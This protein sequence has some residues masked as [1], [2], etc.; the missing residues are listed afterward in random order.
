MRP[1]LR[2]LFAEL[3]RDLSRR[4]RPERHYMRGPGPAWSA[5]QAGQAGG[6]TTAP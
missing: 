5:K 1:S 6:L 4:Y 3:R 2:R